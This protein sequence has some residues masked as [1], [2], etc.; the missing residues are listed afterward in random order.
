MSKCIALIHNSSVII[1]VVRDV[2]ERVYSEAELINIMDESLLR[3]I[4]EK[5][6]I[7]YLGTRRICRYALCAEDM[8]ADAVLMT[9]SSLCEA[10]FAARPL[11]NIPAFAINEPMAQEA[12]NLATNI[13]V[14][15]TLQS[16]LSP[17]VRLIKSKA[18]ESSK[19]V[20]IE[21]AL[22]AAAFEALISGDPQ[23]H[24]ELLIDEV[25]RAAK[26]GDVIVFA[27]GS[28]SRLIPEARKRV[29]I[30]VLEC[31]GSGVKQVK[32]HFES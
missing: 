11:L 6:G 13:V 7:D 24:D 12:V 29:N 22:C 1:D 15:G 9:C 2:F 10:T 8:G 30:P 32:D 16:V 4:K 5:G 17:T 20:K 23:K 3:D 28:M 31:L 27:Q 26:N 21:E 25:A 14:M 19:E 18:I